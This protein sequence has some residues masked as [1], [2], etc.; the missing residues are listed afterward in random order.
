[1]LSF[2]VP[3]VPIWLAWCR[4]F[5]QPGGVF[6]SRGYGSSRED[7]LAPSRVRTDF[8]LISGS[9]FSV[10]TFLYF[11]ASFVVFPCLSVPFFGKRFPFLNLVVRSLKNKHMA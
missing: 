11:G 1:M 8:E 10:S 3:E 4:R 6:A 2:S 5:W 7:T 9:Q